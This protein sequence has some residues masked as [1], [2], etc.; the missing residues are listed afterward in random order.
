[1]PASNRSHIVLPDG[2]NKKGVPNNHWRWIGKYIADKRPDV[3]VNLGDFWDMPSLS[4]YDK[5]KKA[6]EGRRYQIDIDA[7]LRAMDLLMEPIA[8]C[9]G[10][11][12][13]MHFTRGNHEARIIRHVDANPEL[14]GKC[15]YEDL[16]LKQYGWKEYDF[17]EVADI[18]GI[19][20]SHFFPRASSGKVTQTKAGAPGA[21]AQLIREGRSC[22]AG[23]AQGLD[24]ACLPL[25]GRMQWGLIAGACYQHDEDY[26]GPQGNTHWRGVVLKVGVDRGTY[27]PII[28]D[29]DYLRKRYA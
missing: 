14:D 29:L 9:R 17:L 22:T 1:M 7:G 6:A 4:S 13:Q 15:G 3:I 2:Q 19:A 23:H 18:D 12:P 21:R 20:Y 27:S 26:L 5:G 8:K 24:I 10:Y 11:K 28:V 16:K 25:A